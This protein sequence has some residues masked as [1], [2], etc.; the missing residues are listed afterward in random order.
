MNNYLNLILALKIKITFPLTQY[1]YKI[2]NLKSSER[3][4]GVRFTLYMYMV[5]ENLTDIVQPNHGATSQVHHLGCFSA[6]FFGNKLKTTF[7]LSYYCRSWTTLRNKRISR[8]HFCFLFLFSKCIIKHHW[9]ITHKILSYFQLSFDVYNVH[10]SID[11]QC[12]LTIIIH[13]VDIINNYY[14]TILK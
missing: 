8:C 7:K 10:V 12:S 14:N 13:V 11:C 2:Y 9:I 5:G 4:H 1:H 3:E 6:I